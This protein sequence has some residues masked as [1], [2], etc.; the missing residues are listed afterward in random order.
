MDEIN[1][2]VWGGEGGADSL[3]PCAALVG[4]S[5]EKPVA[6]GWGLGPKERNPNPCHMQRSHGKG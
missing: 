5:K 2:R 6:S 3:R 1:A 4:V